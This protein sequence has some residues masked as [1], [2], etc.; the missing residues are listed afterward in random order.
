MHHHI[1]GVVNSYKHTYIHN[2]SLQYFSQDYDLASY[3]TYVVCVNFIHECLDPQFKVELFEKL[4]V[5]FYLFLGVFCHKSTERPSPKIYFLPWDLNQD[6][7][8]NKS[9]PSALIAA[10]WNFIWM[11]MQNHMQ[12]TL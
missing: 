5:A 1:H 9:T 2:S 4:L 3:T 6:L 7:R 8:S 12:N 10:K 11:E